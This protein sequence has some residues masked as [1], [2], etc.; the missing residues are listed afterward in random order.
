MDVLIRNSSVVFFSVI[1]DIFL[2]LDEAGFGEPELSGV[3][4]LLSRS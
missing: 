2:F 4:A 1:S 3:M